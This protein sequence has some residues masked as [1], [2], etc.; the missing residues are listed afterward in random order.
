MKLLARLRAVLRRTLPLPEPVVELGELVVDLEKRA[1][2]CVGRHVHLSPNEFRILRMLALSPGKLLTVRQLLQEICGPG[3]SSG[4]NLL[5]VYIS[6]LRRKPEPDRTGPRYLLT[7][8]GAGYIFEDPVSLDATA[9]LAGLRD[10]GV[11]A[12]KIEGRQRGRA[13]VES[14]VRHFRRALAAL[15]AGDGADPASLTAFTEGQATTVGAYRK[16]WR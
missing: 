5:H 4:R 10:A 2:S 6:Q 7:E 3:Q 14:V 11:A 15:D 1:V 12:L 13:Y 16:T 8:H 9:M